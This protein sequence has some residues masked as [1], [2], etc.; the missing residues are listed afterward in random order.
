MIIILVGPLASGKGTYAELLSKRFNIPHISM[1]ELLRQL[2]EKTGYGR[3]LKRKYW[4]KGLLVPD[5]ITIDV[6][7]Q[8]LNHK[9]FILDGFP[10]NLNQAKLLDGILN[11]D[12]VIYLKVSHDTIIKRVSG[13][14]QCRRCGAVYNEFTNPPKKDALCDKDGSKLYVRPDDTNIKAIRERLSI[15]KK[16][17]LPVIRHYK[18]KGILK[19]IDADADIGTVFDSILRSIRQKSR[20]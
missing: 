6:L 10:R 19:E 15:F 5:D 2:A 16:Q 11:V 4:G 1:G 12:Y 14:L 18:R 20:R 9:G 17:T 3:E 7:Q 8:S 13:R